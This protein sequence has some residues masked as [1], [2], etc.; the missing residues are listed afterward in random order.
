VSETL[1]CFPLRAT[2]ATASSASRDYTH[3]AAVLFQDPTPGHGAAGVSSFDLWSDVA[4][5]V[6]TDEAAVS[7]EGEE[8]ERPGRRALAARPG[9]FHRPER[10]P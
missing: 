5:A 2:T 10:W 6:E 9:L 3:P 4:A 8:Q 7:L 1:A